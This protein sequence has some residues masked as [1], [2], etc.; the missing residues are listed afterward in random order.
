MR[1]A[2]PFG[3]GWAFGFQFRGPAKAD[4]SVGDPIAVTDAKVEV[5]DPAIASAS[6][7]D[8]GK[9]HVKFGSVGSTTGK[10]YSPTATHPDADGKPVPLEVT[11][12]IDCAAESP[13]HIDLDP[14]SVETPA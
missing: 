3:L 2:I 4:G 10:L 8:D 5:A 13:D 12:N 11:F 6:I 14:G 7:G 9:V 1:Y